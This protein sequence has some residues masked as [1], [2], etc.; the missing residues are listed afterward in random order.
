M[1]RPGRITGL[2]RPSAPQ[3]EKEERGS[4]GWWSRRII[5][6]HRLVYRAA[7]SLR[8]LL[9]PGNDEGAGAYADHQRWKLAAAGRTAATVHSPFQTQWK[10]CVEGLG[11]QG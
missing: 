4:A 8:S 5:Q 3:G 6:D 1:R 7:A 9:R 11:H 2:A 10:N